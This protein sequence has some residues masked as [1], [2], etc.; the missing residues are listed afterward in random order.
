MSKTKA[1]E[2]KISS[3]LILIANLCDKIAEIKEILQTKDEN[4]GST[5]ERLMPIGFAVI[6][7]DDFD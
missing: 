5:K 6:S 4:T 7:T 2:Q 1:I 3:A